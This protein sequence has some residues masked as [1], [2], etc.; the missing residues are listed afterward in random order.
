MFDLSLL[1]STLSYMLSFPAYLIMCYKYPNVHRHYRV[2]GGMVGAWIVTL[3]PFAYAAVGSYF[4]LIPSTISSSLGI[5]KTT[6]IVTQFVA[7]GIILLLAI[8]FYVWG[9][10]EKQNR[11]VVVDL[12]LENQSEVVASAG[13]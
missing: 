13:E 2:P 5:D 8:V 10:L 4:I 12:N 9:Q 3:L 11:D 1:T 6:Y 7:L